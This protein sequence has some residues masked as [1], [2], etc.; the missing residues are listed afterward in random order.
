MHL[1]K[2][3]SGQ[4]SKLRVAPIPTVLIKKDAN[5]NRNISEDQ[6]DRLV[7][8]HKTTGDTLSN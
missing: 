6:L 3:K 8:I 1:Y 5:R 7:C 2:P 4:K